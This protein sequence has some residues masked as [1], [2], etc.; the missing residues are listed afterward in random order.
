MVISSGLFL[1]LLYAVNSFQV[2]SYKS[3]IPKL[4]LCH[5]AAP[6][7][8]DKVVR[9]N[10][11][12]MRK[13]VPLHSAQLDEVVESLVP[14]LDI[15]EELYINKGRLSAE[16]V[17]K[18]CDSARQAFLQEDSLVEIPLESTR[19]KD[20]IIIGDTHGQ[21][22]DFV[23]LLD[24]AEVF[25]EGDIQNKMVIVNGD[26]VDRGSQSMEI[27]LVLFYLKQRYPE[28]FTIL[29]GNHESLQMNARFGFQQEVYEK[30]AEDYEAIYTAF[31]RVFRA[32]PLAAT[33]EMQESNQKNNEEKKKIMVCHGGIG[34][35]T[36]KMSLEELKQLDRFVEPF[37]ERYDDETISTIYANDDYVLKEKMPGRQTDDFDTAAVSELLWS[38]PYYAAIE[39]V[40]DED[41]LSFYFPPNRSRGL[42][43]GFL[44]TPK[45]L[46]YF[47]KFNNLDYLVR[48]HQMKSHGYNISPDKTLVTVFSAPNY[49][50]SNNLA[51]F[52]CYEKGTTNMQVT[53]FNTNT[54]E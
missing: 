14:E 29:R 15:I 2:R 23:N 31:Q 4:L 40:E 45:V 24:L 38:D 19:V 17:M 34:R 11:L 7:E 44:F 22:S 36:F 9:L 6:T 39:D 46:D 33:V 37:E 51:A 8:H 13:S 30:Y 28:N 25:K 42:P 5:L 3:Q 47:L 41:P 16:D 53:Q 10:P 21:F 26:F 32:L 52:L 20:V 43:P 18:I 27:A 1:L 49:C 48:S 35:H 12:A 54:E 50:D